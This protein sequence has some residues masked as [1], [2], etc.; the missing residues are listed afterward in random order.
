MPL[1][2]TVKII[3]AIEFSKQAANG[4]IDKNESIS[5]AEL[6]VYY[7]PGT[8]GGAHT[9][10]LEHL[11][12]KD[13]STIHQGKVKLYEVAKG[14]IQIISNANTEYLSDLL[15][16]QQINNNLSALGMNQHEEI[17]YVS[18]SFLIPAYLNIEESLSLNKVQQKMKDTSM[19]DYK[20][21]A[22]TVHDLLKQK[23]AN[24]LI[25]K[26]TRGKVSR[27][28][29]EK[30]QSNRLPAATAKEYAIL[31]N[32]IN[33]GEG[34]TEDVLT[35]LKYLLERK[36]NK[37][38]SHIGFKGGS[39]LFIDANA[40]YVT[41]HEQN[42]SAI[43]MFINDTKGGEMIWIS[44]E[45]NKFILKMLID[46]SFQNEVRSRFSSSA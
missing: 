13:S 10:W 45:I 37:Y 21:Y 17:Y 1:A 7:I 2:S 23:K 6:E 46:K 29:I 19:E 25:D 41:D 14:M 40:F 8:D 44:R 34:F 32:K 16:L 43:G 31:M 3:I 27:F 4:T 33:N 35:T 30:I 22:Q 38:F 28:D 9:S 18:S 11:K 24:H 20:T 26:T 42:K 39:T 5:V 15:G 12:E 36:P